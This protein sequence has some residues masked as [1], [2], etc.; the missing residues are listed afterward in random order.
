MRGLFGD[1]PLIR[2]GAGPRHLLP[3]GEKERDHRPLKF[4]TR[5]SSVALTP[6][7]KSSVAQPR[8]L[9]KFVMGGGEHAVGEA[10]AHRRPRN[11]SGE[12]SAISR[13]RFIAAA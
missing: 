11:P 7:L 5:R 10:C 8:L 13:A 2:R 3:Q 1:V 12:H 6:S 4:G 9:G